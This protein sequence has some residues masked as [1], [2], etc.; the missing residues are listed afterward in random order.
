MAQENAAQWLQSFPA[1][2]A[3]TDP[4][5]RRTIQMAQHII[6]P[7]EAALFRGGEACENYFLMLEGIVKVRKVSES[8]HEIV[9]Y[10]IEAGKVCELTTSCLLADADYP[11]EA[12]AES[13]VRVLLIPK[14][15]FY[16]AMSNSPGFRKFVFSSLDEGVHDLVHLIEEVA[17]GHMDHRLAH[18]LLDLAGQQK[19]VTGT[20]YDLAVELGTAREVVSR[21]L[22]EFEHR[23]WVILHRGRIEIIDQGALRELVKKNRG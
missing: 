11:A 7:A 1:L 5:W 4:V 19:I 6:L 18:H 22:K 23:G 10:R 20:H 9:L 16:E 13:D 14:A 12:V 2:A 17:F 8:G 3:I 21:L 15:R